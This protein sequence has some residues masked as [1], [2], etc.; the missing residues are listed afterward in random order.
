MRT[1]NTD[2]GAIG[3]SLKGRRGPRQRTRPI[4][5]AIRLGTFLQLKSRMSKRN[6]QR[7]KARITTA[8][9]KELNSKRLTHHA[10]QLPQ[11]NTAL[12]VLCIGA[13]IIQLP[14]FNALLV[15]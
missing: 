2:A 3:E 7:L 12:E 4:L 15:G 6:R 11:S 10:I 14:P 8:P 13:D 9:I 1:L 5:Q